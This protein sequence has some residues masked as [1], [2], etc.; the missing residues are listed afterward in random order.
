MTDPRAKPGTDPFGSSLGE[1][2][3]YVSH[4]L[5]QRIDLIE[6]LLEFGRQLIVLSGP[7]GSGKTTLLHAI[8]VAAGERWACVQVQGGP[9]LSGRALLSQVA[10]ALDVDLSADSEP[11]MAQTMLRLRLN[12]LERAG[13]LV[14]LLVDD[15]DQLPPDAVAALVALARTE[16]QTAEARVLMAADLDHAGLLANL[17]RDRPQHGLVHV[18]EI[19]PVS[20]N[21]VGDFLAQ[22]LT[23]AGVALGERFSAA[24][25]A[26]IASAAGGNPA[27]IVALARQQ[28]AGR[29]AAPRGARRGSPGRQGIPRFPSLPGLPRLPRL[30]SLPRLPRLEALRLP[31]LPRLEALRLPRL[32][33]G[34]LRRPRLGDPRLL[35]LF[36]LPPIVA[37]GAWLLLRDAGD[38]APPAPAAVTIELPTGEAAPVDAP[39][40]ATITASEPPAAVERPASEPP[41]TPVGG[42]DYEVIELEVP[43]EPSPSLDDGAKP[44]SGPVADPALPPAAE[45]EPS[46]P[47]VKPAPPPPTPAAPAPAV[48]PAP[49]VEK[50]PPPQPSPVPKTV[51]PAPEPAGGGIASAEWL[52]K[53][54][55]GSYTLQLAGVRD[56]AAAQRFIQRHGLG[57]KAAILTTRREGQ[58][59]YVLVHGY[60]PNRQAALA[61]ATRLSPALLKEVK[62]WARTIGDL[63][64]LPR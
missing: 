50:R 17:Q 44:E 20:D 63:A 35:P 18:V 49:K 61:A 43:D 33:A 23:S 55:R 52:L 13:K 2:G 64:A 32:N 26:A 28:L 60:Y 36:L 53:Q 1:G 15:A 54:P 58:A 10:D 8:G 25:V 47:A 9:A 30:P 57:G 45:P 38:E 48:P 24:D 14:V 37:V 5:Q 40:V 39:T 41:T 34:Q 6:H 42:G 62:P 21:H 12:M 46:E 31:R 51:E 4:T 11:R 7:A 16:D 29:E 22:R 19:P 27:R 3:L 59:W 56:R